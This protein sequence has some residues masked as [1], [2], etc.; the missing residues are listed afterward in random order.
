MRRWI[1]LHLLFAV[2]CSLAFAQAAPKWESHVVSDSQN[3]STFTE[4]RLQGTYVVPPR[5][6]NEQPALIVRCA[7]GKVLENYFSFGAVLSQHT[8][9]LYLVELEAM[10]DNRRRPIGVDEVSPDGMS[11]YFPRKE[12]KRMLNAQLVTIGA[13]EFAGPQMLAKFEMPNSEPVFSACGEDMFLK[14]K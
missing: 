10:I 11:A 8:G 9:G 13:V 4:L 7:N 12:L 14:H 5:M 3:G 6:S 2:M 1:R